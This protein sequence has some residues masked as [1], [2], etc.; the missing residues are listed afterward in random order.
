ML[1]ILGTIGFDWRVAVANLVSFLIIYWILKRY[2]FGPVRAIIDE[3]TQKIQEGLDKAQ[4]SET[5]LL[6]AQQKA[7]ETIKDAKAEANIIVANAKDIADQ[8]VASAKGRAENE[9]KGV[10]EKAQAQIERDRKTMETELFTKTANLVALG[11]EKLLGEEVDESK[12]KDLKE[13]AAKA[14]QER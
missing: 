4:Q 5:E 12:D 10:M 3:R 1:D 2:V 7:D 9:A 6:V 8:E 13:R 11:V 14:M